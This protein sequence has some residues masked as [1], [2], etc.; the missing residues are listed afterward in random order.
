MLKIFLSYT[1]MRRNFLFK[2]I[3]HPFTLIGNVLIFYLAIL[4]L[5]K[6]CC[7]NN[8]TKSYWTFLSQIICNLSKSKGSILLVYFLNIQSKTWNMEKINSN[9]YIFE[10][11]LINSVF[12]HSTVSHIILFYDIYSIR[13]N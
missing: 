5:R 7:T 8:W 12:S 3:F 1:Y 13:R 10:N 6:A 2:F 9:T 4:F 11:I